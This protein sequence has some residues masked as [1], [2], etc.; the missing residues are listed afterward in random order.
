MPNIEFRGIYIK[1]KIN[2]K[3]H[4][5]YILPKL[6]AVCYAVRIIKPYMSLAMLKVVYYCNFY[7]IIDY[8]L[9]FWGTSPHS[10]KIFRM[11]K[12][13]VRIFDRL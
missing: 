4:I 13:I 6:S 3:Y 5:E 12:R 1:D 11:E 9:P 2:W 7:S 10:K 8:G